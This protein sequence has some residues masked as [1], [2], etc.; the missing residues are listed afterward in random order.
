M[1]KFNILSLAAIAFVSA[2]V[3][4][5]DDETPAVVEENEVPDG[6]ITMV[7]SVHVRPSSTL[8]AR[9]QGL[10]GVTVTINQNGG[11][12]TATTDA[13]GIASFDNMRQGIASI[14]V[15]GPAGFISV[16]ITDDIDCFDCEYDQL[17]TDQTEYD[18]L[19][20]DLP[21]LGATVRGQLLADVDFNGAT[22]LQ[23][24]PNTA[25]VIATIN[26]IYE[27]NVYRVPV[28][29][30][31]T[32]SFT[33]LPEGVTTTLTVDFKA[34]D[35]ITTPAQP[36]ERTFGFGGAGGD[37]NLGTLSVNNPLSIGDQVL[38]F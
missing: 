26:N 9:T 2:F 32:F 17:D 28:G 20:I 21:R 37:L 14:F 1:K 33:N 35:A 36:V 19:F 7:Y 11:I 8:S 30:D 18:Q 10:A 29:N 22:A 23:S 16:N 34:T 5:C 6:A 12:I 4:S 25:F 24:V 3:M 13:S 15:Q 38:D 31:G 27:P